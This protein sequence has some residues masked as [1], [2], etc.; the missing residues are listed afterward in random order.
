MLSPSYFILPADLWNV[1]ATP[2]TPQIVDARRRD[3]FEQSPHLIPGAVW[4]D[5]SLA[6]QWADSLDRS[7]PIVVAC[8]AGHELSQAAVAH[9]RAG[10]VAARVLEGGYEAWGTSGLP[11]LAKPALDRFA[12]TWPSL[13]VA[14]RRPKIDAWPVRG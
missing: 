3:V 5:F 1:I 6:A 13:W 4:R 14:R 12:P 11:F 9:L 7:R 2:D 8:K 10:G